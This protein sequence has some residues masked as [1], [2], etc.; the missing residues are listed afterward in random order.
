MKLDINLIPFDKS[1]IEN[2]SLILKMLKF[3]DDYYLS[4]EGQQFLKDYGKNTTSLEGS[5]SIQ[6]L[7]L[8]EFGFESKEKDLKNYRSIF[9][10]YYNSPNDYDKDILNSVYYM[11]ENRCLYYNTKPIKIGDIIPN[12]NIY[13]LDGKTT[14]DIYSILKEKNYDKTI[15]GAFSLS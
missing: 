8:N 13:K 5:K 9:N 1:Q 11:R 4:D 15:I 10:Y 2:K 3:E 14:T 12:V 6:R 7:T